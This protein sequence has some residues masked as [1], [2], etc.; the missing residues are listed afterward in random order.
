MIPGE[1]YK[2]TPKE[3]RERLRCGNCSYHGKP[4]CI[5]KEKNPTENTKACDEFLHTDSV[6]WVK[7]NVTLRSNF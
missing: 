7:E 3:R 5:K 4:S 2:E 6:R 1:T